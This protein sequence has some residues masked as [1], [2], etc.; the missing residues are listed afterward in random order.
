MTCKR[1]GTHMEVTTISETKRRG[2]FAILIYIVLLFVLVIGWI[3]LF[4]L[5]GDSKKIGA[6]SY[7]IC[8]SCGKR[9][10]L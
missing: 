10:K 8:P 7:S 3:A 9:D 4:R 2:C 5:L 6:T 1:C